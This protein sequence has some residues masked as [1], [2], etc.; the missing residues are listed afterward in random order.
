[1]RELTLTEVETL[2]REAVA[3]AQ[4]I[5]RASSVAVVD[6]GGHL[7]GAL[8]P[9]KGRIINAPIAEKKAWTA[10]AFKRPTDM[11]RNIMVPGAMGYGLQHTD[12]RICIVGGGYP[13]LDEQD[14][15]I[16]GIGVS[17]GTVEEDKECCLAGMRK[18]GFKTEFE[19][20]FAGVSVKA[21]EK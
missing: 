8:R 12:N 17:G 15:V 1:M 10:A 16:G 7:R 18:V 20:P 13:L 6:M 19:D 21:E 2:M 4:S 9:E 5:G 11:V 3:Y 14:D